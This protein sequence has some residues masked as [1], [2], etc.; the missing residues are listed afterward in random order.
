MMT[1]VQDKVSRRLLFVFSVLMAFA[2]AAQPAYS[3]E[4][5]DLKV[6]AETLELPADTTVNIEPL[7][8]QNEDDGPTIILQWC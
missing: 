5:K 4:E 6:Q 2:A 1:V 8:D 7:V 3:V